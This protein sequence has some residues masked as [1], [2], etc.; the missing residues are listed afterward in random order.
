LISLCPLHPRT[1]LMFCVP[2][3]STSLLPFPVLLR[4]LILRIFTAKLC[5]CLFSSLPFFFSHSLAVSFIV[6][7]SLTQAPCVF[8]HHTLFSSLVVSRFFFHFR[9]AYPVFLTDGLLKL[10]TTA[11]LFHLLFS[12]FLLLSLV[13][14]ALDSYLSLSYLMHAHAHAHLFDFSLRLLLLLM[15]LLR[16]CRPPPFTVP[17]SPVKKKG[18]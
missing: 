6:A 15:L 16:R 1:L 7:L 5:V 11:S 14:C 12:R 3:T 10:T 9:V 8:P 4:N 18:L 17:S 2:P 13:T